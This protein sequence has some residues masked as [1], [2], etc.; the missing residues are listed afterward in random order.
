MEKTDSQLRSPLKN[1]RV[2]AAERN[3][4]Y[5]VANALGV[6]SLDGVRARGR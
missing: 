6:R 3:L 4:R 2:E 1:G 5:E